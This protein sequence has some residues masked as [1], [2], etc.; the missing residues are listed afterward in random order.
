MKPKET[1]G[2]YDKYGNEYVLTWIGAINCFGIGL[3]IGASIIIWL[4]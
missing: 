2:V 1:S 3:C 4:F